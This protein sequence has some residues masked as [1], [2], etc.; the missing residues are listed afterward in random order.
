MK[1]ATHF[2]ISSYHIDYEKN[3]IDFVYETHLEDGEILTSV[4]SLTLPF[5]LDGHDMERV[6]IKAALEAIHMIIGTSYFKMYA[7]KKIVHPYAFK[8]EQATFWNTMYTQG[9]GE[10]YYVNAIDFRKYALFSSDNKESSSHLSSFFSSDKALVLHGGGKDSI[11]SVEIAKKAE[12]DF[13]IISLHKSHIQELAA[14]AIGKK[15]INVE[16]KL[17]QQMLAKTKSGE[18][19]NGHT[20]IVTVYAFI[21]VLYALINKYSYIV[22]SH[23]A[24]ANY[25]NVEYLGMQVNHQWDKSIDAEKLIQTYI[26]HNITCDVTYFSLLRPLHELTIVEIFTHYPQ[27]FTKFSSSN[28]NF[29]QV[30]GTSS[31]WDLTYSKG[32][33]E[34]IF[35][36]FSAWVTKDTMLHIF[37]DIYFDHN[38]LLQRYKELLGVVGVKPLDCVGTPEETALALY[39]ASKNGEY[40]D[41]PIMKYFESEVL[42]KLNIDELKNEVFAYGDDSCIPDQFKQALKSM[43]TNT[44]VKA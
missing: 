21:A 26:A 12:M 29:T 3:H 1:K 5:H 13:D 31:R 23:E 43:L 4:D 22:A 19:L 41:S 8:P 7:P 15:L 11:V 2:T 6:D 20:P 35:A 40:S 32:K 33:V 10:Y 39:L 37:D 27:Y 24:S 16:R 18:V 36:L 44:D 30:D 25:G 38:E 17:D 34:F 14:E 42:P 9:M 28:H